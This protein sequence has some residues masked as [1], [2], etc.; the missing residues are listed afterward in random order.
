MKVIKAAGQQAA[1]TTQTIQAAPQHSMA[2]QTINVPGS[3][4]QPGQYNNQPFTDAMAAV[5]VSLRGARFFEASA[6]P[7]LHFCPYTINSDNALISQL[8]DVTNGGLCVDENALRGIAGKII[9]VSD[10][11]QGEIGIAGGWS[12]RRCSV[13]LDFEVQSG[14]MIFREILTGY[15]DS[16]LIVDG[17]GSG[18]I[19]GDVR[20]YV[21]GIIRVGQR[22]IADHQGQRTVM[23]VSSNMQVLR[24]ITVNNGQSIVTTER[25][26]RS[27]DMVTGWQSVIAGLDENAVDPRNDLNSPSNNEL[28]VGAS[29][30]GTNVASNFLSNVL[31]SFSTAHAKQQYDDF[32]NDDRMMLGSVASQ[33]RED[34]LVGATM[35]KL[36]KNRTSY[37]ATQSFSWAELLTSMTAVNE[38]GILSKV[39]AHVPDYANVQTWNAYGHEAK[40]ARELTHV[41]PAICTQF[42]ASAFTFSLTNFGTG[43]PT[44]LPSNYQCMFDDMNSNQF[45]SALVNTIVTHVAP[46]IMTAERCLTYE[47]KVTYVVGGMMD[48]RIKLDG[49][50]QETPFLLPCYC[51]HLNSPAHALDQKQVNQNGVSLGKVV[52]ETFS[53]HAPEQAV[54][55]V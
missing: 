49:S 33:L 48:I 30:M 50:L 40:I 54:T 6:T 22:R 31:Q 13:F 5:K 46:E 23:N 1:P 37:A 18:K 44:I 51:D 42:M 24:P 9:N 21:N 8:Q 35:F 36:L 20:I 12:S 25:T 28:G 45:A 39:I 43:K 29:R 3:I 10:T 27:T 32:R 14:D 52:S 55:F 4:N 11:T 41:I 47:V 15:T 34:S 7:A 38:Q 16:N 2:G 53:G 17:I 19:A 26:Q